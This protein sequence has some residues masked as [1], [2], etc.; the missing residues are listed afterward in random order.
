MDV[1]AA[2]TL[3]VTAT[4]ALIGYWLTYRNNLRLAQRQAWREWIGNLVSSTVHYWQVPRRLALRGR[5]SDPRSPHARALFGARG[6]LLLRK[7][8]RLGDYG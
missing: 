6:R 5:A 3:G 1:A 2:V 7:K 4:L 8:Q